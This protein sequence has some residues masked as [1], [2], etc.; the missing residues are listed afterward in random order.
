M[1]G[2]IEDSDNGKQLKL[3]G[4]L[5]IQSAGEFK[6]ILKES[7]EATG[8]LAINVASVTEIDLSCLQLLCAAHRTSI[9]Q[10]KL[11]EYE[12]GWPEPFID[13]IRGSGYARHTNCDLHKNKKCIFT[14]HVHG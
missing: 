12:Q 13:A 4:E 7:L 14:E 11:F 3:S 6:A 9:E 1:Y 8:I 10:D 2:Q 5:T